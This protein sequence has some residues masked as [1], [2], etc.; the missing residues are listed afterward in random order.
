MRKKTKGLSRLQRLIILLAVER[1]GAVARRDVM[2]SYYG[3]K[4]FNNSQQVVVI[5]SI[6]RLV[7]R[8]LVMYNYDG[9]VRLRRALKG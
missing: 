5:K 1:G 8:G 3:G 6:D 2:T 4:S 7:M 9:I